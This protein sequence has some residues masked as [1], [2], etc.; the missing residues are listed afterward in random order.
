M[1]VLHIVPA[2]EPE[3]GG[4]ARFV[5]ALCQALYVSGVE[6]SL[7]TFRARKGA[8]VDSDGLSFPVH[9][10]KAGLGTH[11]FPTLTFY[12]EIRQN[13]P[14]YDLVHLHSL[15]NPVISLAAIACRHAGVPY[16]LSPLGMLQQRALRRKE[17]LKQIYYQLLENRTVRG[18]TA[19]HFFTEAETRDSQRLLKWPKPVFVVPSGIDASLA[20]RVVKGE[21]RQ[22][23]SDLKGKR[24]MLFLGRLHWS[25]GLDLQVE[26]LAFLVR[27]FPD[28][29][30][31]L[32]GPDGGEWPRLSRRI[33]ALGLKHHTLWT[34]LLPHAGCLKALADADVFVLT[35]RHEA[36]SVAMNEA[37]ACGVPIVITDTVSFDGI[38]QWGAGRVTTWE[39]RNLAHAIGEV[40]ANPQQANDM[41]E[42]G[43]RMVERC[44]AWPK[45][46]EAM[47]KA[48]E[49]LLCHQHQVPGAVSSVL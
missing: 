3:T 26:A 32:V 23:F 27:D 37:L 13:I 10:F 11:Q 47:V 1:R 46:A 19:I 15:W 17:R 40:L 38:Q 24:I 5:P 41:R 6:V 33:A 48:Y 39:A 29:M 28:L 36:H 43:R 44:L 9:E 2:L 14:H 7:Y 34:G 45:V 35:S 21:F 31:V 49:E 42:A 25:K 4:P 8:G 22:A 18:A 12:R 20:D 30:W 16:M